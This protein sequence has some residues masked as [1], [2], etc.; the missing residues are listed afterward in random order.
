SRDWSSD[1]CSSDLTT[2]NNTTNTM[3]MSM[4]NTKMY[5]SC[6]Q[7]TLPRMTNL[8]STILRS[9]SGSPLMCTSGAMARN[10]NNVYPT[11]W[12]YRYSLPEGF[13]AY[14]HSRLGLVPSVAFPMVKS[15]AGMY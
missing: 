11:H 3:K 5:K 8:R 7:N 10:S 2:V 9:S 4:P 12:R 15:M 14:T 13:L 6:G 1:V